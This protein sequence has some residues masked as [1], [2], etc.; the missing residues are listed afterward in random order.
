MFPQTAYSNSAYGRARNAKFFGKSNALFFGIY[1]L[2]YIRFFENCPA[3][4]FSTGRQFWIFYKRAIFSVMRWRL[5]VATFT[6]SISNIIFLRPREKMIWTTARRIVAV[7]QN[8]K[9]LRDWAYKRFIRKSVRFKPHAA[10][11]YNLPVLPTGG[12]SFPPPT[13]IGVFNNVTF[14][15]TAHR[16]K[17]ISAL[18]VKLDPTNGTRFEHAFT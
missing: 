15:I 11:Y 1:Y 16:T 3:V 4:F 8:Q 17:L 7:V 12:R 10:S 9:P 13:T 18:R 2:N 6:H 14:V 5:A